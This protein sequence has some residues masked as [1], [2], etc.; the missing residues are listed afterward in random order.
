MAATK[1]EMLKNI[2][3]L[4]GD[5]DVERAEKL[6]SDLREHGFAPPVISASF[7]DVGVKLEK[8]GIDIAILADSLGGRVFKLSRAVR[9]G[10][11]GSNPFMTLYCALAPEHVDGAKH[12]L[13]AGVDGI[14]IQPV[15]AKEI[16]D[17]VRK[18]GRTD[19]AYV[20][21]SEYIGP[22]RR[23]ADRASKIR[24]FYVPQTVQAKLRGQD[25]DY[26][27]FAK[28]VAPILEDMMQTRLNSQSA[29]L[30]ST[31][32]ELAGL[33]Q[34]GQI[35][36]VVLD[37]L[38]A[39]EDLL[40][41]AA[42]TAKQIDQ[43]DVSV[44]CI[45]LAE[46]IKA[47]AEHYT[48]PSEKDLNLL[49]KIADA[50]AMAARTG[51][52]VD[53]KVTG[54]DSGVEE[55]AALPTDELGPALEIQ[56]LQKGQQ[57]FKEGDEAS[58]AYVVAAGCI[59]IFRKVAGKTS[60]VARIRSGEFFG[61]MAIL[62]GSKRRATAVALED[63][64]V[65][66]VSKEHLE[67]KMAGTDKLIRTILLSA[68]H[69]LRT[70]HDTYT[71]RGRSLKDMFDTLNLSAHIAGRHAE[72]VDLGDDADAAAELLAQF[73]ETLEDLQGLSAPAIEDDQRDDQIL[74]TQDIQEA[75]E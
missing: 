75:A 29:R 45:S 47:F 16:T 12:A 58:A 72:R 51:V 27:D 13:R 67:E 38:R 65:S 1:V 21:T 4:I 55:E 37:K 54:I 9:H 32:K 56:F 7:N 18:A 11:I 15:P 28:K 33:Y 17:R 43:D 71:Q 50:V 8:G 10:L 63:T 46:K 22:D 73:D 48:T 25:L 30:S 57:L 53:A 49:K 64:T 62:D 40:K 5:T 26:K 36:P 61:E 70:A 69:N 74:N 60:P 23:A 52:A 2:A 31:C 68:V 41:D 66:L 20:V 19:M 59:G 34:T 42:A 24:R 6:A 39:L 35:T 44:L 3:V 14:L